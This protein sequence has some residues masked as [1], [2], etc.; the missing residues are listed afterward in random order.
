LLGD[1]GS[2][3]TEAPQRR[4]STLVIQPVISGELIPKVSP[5]RVGVETELRSL[6]VLPFA[7]RLARD[8]AAQPVAVVVRRYLH[9]CLPVL[10]RHPFWG[11]RLPLVQ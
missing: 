10:R 9:A 6:S 11:A 3:P 7:K 4:G 5:S 2:P 1:E 8:I